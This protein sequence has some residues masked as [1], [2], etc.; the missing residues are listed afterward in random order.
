LVAE[1]KAVIT[2]EETKKPESAPSLQPDG[3]KWDVTKNYKSAM[4][5]SWNKFC[6]TGG[7]MEMSVRM[8]ADDKVP[9]FWPAFWAMGNLGRAGYMPST[10]G[11]WPYSYNECGKGSNQSTA[12]PGSL[13]PSQRVSACILNEGDPGYINRTKYGFEEGKARN[14]PEFDV[15]EVVYV[16]FLLL[17]LLVLL[18]FI[19]C[20]YGF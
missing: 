15:F 11:F 8:P 4:V 3:T 19:K 9:G 12:I 20:L 14:S 13:V 6:F 2:I 18:T 17:S 5:N 1:G 16:S 10:G 7:Y